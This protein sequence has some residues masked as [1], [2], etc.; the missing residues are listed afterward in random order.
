SLFSLSLHD[1]LPIYRMR[2][3]DQHP[4]TRCRRNTWHHHHARR[5]SP[6]L[7][8]SACKCE[9]NNDGSFPS[10][11]RGN[12]HSSELG[13]PDPVHYRRSRSEEHTSELQSREK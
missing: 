8:D 1:A 4:T 6:S 10:Y 5:L 13:C 7:S 3:P 12:G 11:F 2:F 9:R